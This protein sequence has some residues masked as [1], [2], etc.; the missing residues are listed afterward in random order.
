MNDK[1]DI[2]ILNKNLNRQDDPKDLN[3]HGK[4]P[5]VDLNSRLRFEK[6]AVEKIASVAAFQV[7]GV[8]D[9]KGGMISG[10]QETFGSTD[11]TK[12]VTAEL[13]EKEA[14]FDINIIMEHGYSA[15]K[16]YQKIK[17]L[18]MEHVQFMTGLEVVEINLKVV[19]LMTKKE[20]ENFKNP[21]TKQL[22]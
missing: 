3:V 2:N 4:K 6:S 11:I 18:V 13:G 14:A 1:E 12:G 19:D 15:Q 7:E 22:N 5:S 16:V 21:E 17:K 10:I 8:L 9:L 20:Y